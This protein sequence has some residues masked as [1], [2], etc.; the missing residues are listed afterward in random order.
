[1][2]PGVV[3]EQ[4]VRPFNFYGDG[5]VKQGMSYQLQLFQLVQVFNAQQR[6]QAYMLGCDL[7]DR[8]DRSMITA[9]KSNYKVWVELRSP[10]AIRRS[11]EFSSGS[12][13]SL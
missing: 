8:G 2:L 11:D 12:L 7:A 9:S 1:M 4:S 6:S 13:D 3:P 10:D 5:D